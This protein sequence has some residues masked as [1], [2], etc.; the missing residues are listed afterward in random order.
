MR[1]LRIIW[2][3]RELHPNWRGSW[4][5]RAPV[6]KMMRTYAAAVTREAKLVAPEGKIEV[7]LTFCPP[8]RRHR[9]LDSMQSAFKAG[10]DGIADALK[11]NDRMFRPVSDWGE[12][13]PEGKGYVLVELVPW[14]R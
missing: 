3:P 9:D 12:V 5:K 2:P 10:F 7:R 13:D 6:T 11:V 1:P 8:D 14:E 4:R